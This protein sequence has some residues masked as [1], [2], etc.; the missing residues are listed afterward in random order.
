MRRYF[1]IAI[2][3]FV[4]INPVLAQGYVFRKAY[5]DFAKKTW[6][7]YNE[8]RDNANNEYAEFVKQAWKEYKIS[9]AILKPKDNNIPPINYDENKYQKGNIQSL[10][11]DEIIDNKENSSPQPKPISPIREN[12]EES[13]IKSFTFYG[14]QMSVRVPISF[15]LNLS[16]CN[17]DE[18]A[19]GW[20][21]LSSKKYNNLI[22]DCL[23]IRIKYQLCDWAYLK[24]LQSLS[25]SVCGIGSNEATLLQ[26]Y[27]YC[28]SGYKM[29]LAY[30]KVEKL[31]LLF[32]SDYDIFDKGAYLLN[33]GKYYVFQPSL[34]K[35]LFI[36]DVEFPGE[37]SLKLDILKN[38]LLTENVSEERILRTNGDGIATKTKVN[39][40][41]MDFYTDYPTGFIGDNFM[42]RWAVYANTPLDKHLKDTLYPLLQQYIQGKSQLE[43]ADMLLKYVQTAFKYEYDDKVWGH[44]RAFFAEETLYYPYCDCEDRSI[45]YTRLVRDLLN[46]DAILIYYPGHLAAAIAFDTKVKGDYIDLRDKRFTITDPTYIGAPVGATMPNMNNMMAKV[47]LLNR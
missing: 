34:E 17:E 37:Q 29:R 16:K 6:S 32:Q 25:E 36:C 43:A 13:E 41:L 27:I 46:L 39:K 24:M 14:T 45:L 18:F 4:S 11:Y 40:N 5:D 12:N 23:E 26:S 30:S 3:F 28:Q 31:Y 44:D 2:L 19:K 21:E 10:P 47:I 1:L 38:M 42:S 20:E 33:G 35:D 22:R 8:F 7:E 15:N 9:P